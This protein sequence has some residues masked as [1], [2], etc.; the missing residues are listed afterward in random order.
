MDFAK[1]CKTKGE[2][3][4]RY[5]HLYTYARKH[6]WINEIYTLSHLIE[7]Q[8]DWISDISEFMK[9][10]NI[11][12]YGIPLNMIFSKVIIHDR[13]HITFVLGTC[14]D[15]TSI[16]NMDNDILIEEESYYIRKSKHC[17]RFGIFIN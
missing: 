15:V 6:G 9:D 4:N 17:A 3:I 13:D 16:K 10:G 14:R 12:E 2:F 7:K 8:E 1:Q 11:I 5:E